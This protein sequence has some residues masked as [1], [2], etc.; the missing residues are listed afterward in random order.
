MILLIDHDDSFVF[1]LAR[2]VAELGEE[3]IVVRAAEISTE[4]VIAQP[5]GRIIL[6]PGPGKPHDWPIAIQIVR[7]LGQTVP[8]LGVCLGHQCVAAA[9]GASVQR[10]LHPRH[11]RTSIIEHDSRGVLRDVPSPFRAARYHSLA[12]AAT[13]LPPELMVTAVADDGDVM[14]VRHRVHP[15]EGVQFH[16]ESVL[17]EWGYR[18]LANFLGVTS[19]GFGMEADQIP[20]CFT[21]CVPAVPESLRS[22]H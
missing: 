12:V 6:S 4:A 16:P 22:S 10:T 11:G 17:T 3:A 15:V 14:G 13:N 5:P 21:P 18:M 7:A 19:I 9:Y 20:L 2:Y 1:T 8:I